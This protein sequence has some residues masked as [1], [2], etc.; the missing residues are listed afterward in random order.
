MTNPIV[1]LS[2]TGKS[3]PG[4]I[5]RTAKQQIAQAKTVAEVKDIRDKAIAMA[6]Y[7]LQAKNNELKAEAEVI[8]ASFGH[9]NST[10]YRQPKQ[11]YRP[12]DMELFRG[13]Y[14]A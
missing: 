3:H 12:L 10:R 14:R 4:L 8:R 11:R 1:P 2:A 7:A 6:V 13:H 5:F 9:A